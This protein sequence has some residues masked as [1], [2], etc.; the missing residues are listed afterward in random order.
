VRSSASTWLDG[1]SGL[2]VGKLNLHQDGHHSVGKDDGFTIYHYQNVRRDDSK[3]EIAT[4][5]LEAIE[6]IKDVGQN[7]I[8]KR[9]MQP[10]SSIQ[11]LAAQNSTYSS[12]KL[13]Q[14]VL[15]QTRCQNNKQ[16]NAIKEHTCKGVPVKIIL[17]ALAYFLI[18][19]TSL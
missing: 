6:V 12:P 9:P 7:E 3:G 17:L 10:F 1:A 13:R 2:E 15:R 8:K 5:L 18:S 16:P 19:C 14:V 11:A 4:Y